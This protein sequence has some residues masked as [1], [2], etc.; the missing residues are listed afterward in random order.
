MFYCV[1]SLRKRS[2][3]GAIQEFA[4]SAKGLTKGDTLAEIYKKGAV[5]IWFEEITQEDYDILENARIRGEF[6]K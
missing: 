3:E 4:S 1:A 2:P 6:C 5:I